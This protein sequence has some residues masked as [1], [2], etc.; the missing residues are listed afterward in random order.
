MATEV[1]KQS[2]RDLSRKEA[3]GNAE[4]LFEL[5]NAYLP[6]ASI[7]ETDDSLFIRLD[8]PGVEKGQ[9]H[10][11]VDESNNLQ[12]RAKNSFTE[13]A[14]SIFREFM[15]GDFFRSFR[16][17]EEFAKDAIVAKLEDGVI[18]L[19]VPKR[20]EVKPRRISINA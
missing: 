8:A 4:N 10:I 3:A 11:E 20:E 2:K 18:E 19:T 15:I 1:Q 17:S 5:E 12:I 9:V 13:P 6:D 14:N 16:L 7:Y